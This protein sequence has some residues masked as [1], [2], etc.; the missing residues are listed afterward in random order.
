MFS[1]GQDT[2]PDDSFGFGI[3]TKLEKP[4]KADSNRMITRSWAVP[5]SFFRAIS[6]P[7][8]PA[9]PFNPDATGIG[10]PTLSAKKVL[11]SAGVVFPKGAAAV[12]KP[13]SSTLIVRNTR[14]QMELVEIYGCFHQP[15]PELLVHGIFEFIEL[16][17][18]LY[19][20]WIDE[21]RISDS[22]SKLRQAAQDW[23]QSG[24]AKIVETI[25]ITGRSGN[26]S[27]SESVHE[28]VGYAAKDK[29]KG[30]TNSV[31][32]A[33]I[34]NA[35]TR[36]LMEP[37]VGADNST[38][39]I[40]YILDLSSP[41]KPA[42]DAEELLYEH[43]LK[44]NSHLTIQSGS[45]AL[46]GTHRPSNSISGGFKRPIVLQFVRADI[47]ALPM[48]PLSIDFP[49]DQK[50]LITRKYRVPSDLP[51]YLGWSDQDGEKPDVRKLLVEKG[52]SMPDKAI[53][54]F[55][56]PSATLSVTNFEHNLEVV[57]SILNFVRRDSIVQ[58]H[59]LQ[60]WIEVDH[61]LFSNWLYA[62]KIKTDGTVLRDLAQ[63]WINEG[64]ASVVESLLIPCK[65]DEKGNTISSSKSHKS[66]KM[67]DSP[68]G[69]ELVRPAGASLTIDAML[70]PDLDTVNINLAPEIAVFDHSERWRE[71]KEK[72]NLP[73]VHY[74]KITSQVVAQNG[75]Y[76]FIG[77]T[78]PLTSSKPEIT[79][80]PLILHFVR[81]DL[82]LS[83]DWKRIED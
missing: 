17:S 2:K 9:D 30:E 28:L 39:S 27:E 65:T 73:V 71:F 38:L 68:S 24:N 43:S 4:E 22:G 48:D 5:P 18:D 26:R 10:L 50:N 34:I 62:N 1:Q 72:S 49:D 3:D 70:A 58:I 69:L 67:N 66:L 21:N 52:L 54:K 6:D 32:S 44:T 47:A 31:Y 55:D 63:L 14:E 77:A 11:E 15:R 75:R 29:H 7:N 81:A 36:I 40:D 13:A 53:V 35:G 57:E 61:E 8:T 82:S 41:P 59:A 16:E 80:N 45:Y 42:R 56:Q 20:D 74:Q 78:R 33:K 60:E 19:Q 83:R 51:R 37:V 12:Y 64:K 25:V 76:A 23:V 79:T 46:A